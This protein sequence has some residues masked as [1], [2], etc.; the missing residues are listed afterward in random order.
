MPGNPETGSDKEVP[1]GELVARSRLVSLS[2]DG[3]PAA[4]TPESHPRS[5]LDHAAEETVS[6]FSRVMLGEDDTQSRSHDDIEKYGKMFAKAVPLFVDRKRAVSLAIG[7]YGADQASPTD[8]AKTQVVDFA[9]GGTKGFVMKNTLAQMG[10]WKASP[11]MK[12]IGLGITSRVVDTGLTRH[13]W[14]DAK[15]GEISPGLGMQKTIMAAADPR[16]VATDALLFGA[17]EFTM[18][19]LNYATK[20]ALYNH[21]ALPVMATG[22]I[23]GLG[24]GATEEVLRQKHANEDFDLSKVLYRASMASMTNTLAAGV[25]GLDRARSF[26][27]PP[28]ELRRVKADDGPVPERVAKFN[29]LDPKQIEFSSPLTIKKQLNDVA[30]L[31]EVNPA[32]GAPKQ[33]IFRVTDT[34][35]MQM[36]F[37]NEMLDYRLHRAMNPNTRSLTIAENQATINGVTR[38][39]YVQELAGKS[40]EDHLRGMAWRTDGL[41]TDRSAARVLRKDPEL[42]QQYEQVWIQKM[43][44]R[45]WDNH[46]H[47]KVAHSDGKMSTIDHADLMPAARYTTD[48]I[49]SWGKTA[50]RVSLL[51][52][53][54][55]GQLAGKPLSTNSETMLKSF[56]RDFDTSAGRK[57]L[58]GSGHDAAQVD[59]LLGRARMLGEAGAF[60]TR[61]VPNIFVQASLRGLYWLRKGASPRFE[62]NLKE[63]PAQ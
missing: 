14:M 55:I 58:Q 48:Y 44:M 34:P 54:L 51:N 62:E 28:V 5:Y 49:P 6:L 16:A 7:V 2:G 1:V 13:T 8:S 17:A 38:K 18:G 32:G 42:L 26:R 52:D 11:A 45:Q 4:P 27:L 3:K 15:T 35:E 63:K 47:N 37:S 59:G 22:G 46:A 36:R 12:G 53:R 31:A 56:V 30:F 43:L 39:G 57:A 29:E 9:L 40:F 21:P 23:Y 25:G 41:S 50:S 60:P 33:V 61:D 10:A 19:R 20:G 24:S